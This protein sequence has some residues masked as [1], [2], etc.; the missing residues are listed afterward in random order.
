MDSLHNL[1]LSLDLQAGKPCNGLG[2]QLALACST[3]EAH[4]AKLTSIQS[5]EE[6]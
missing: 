4:G 3:P 2:L 6:P 1:R 5:H